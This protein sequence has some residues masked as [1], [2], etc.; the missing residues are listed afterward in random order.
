MSNNISE[1]LINKLKNYLTNN[2]LKF[3]NEFSE[4][5]EYDRTIDDSHEN[6]LYL[7]TVKI[8]D[9]YYYFTYDYNKRNILVKFEILNMNILNT[10]FYYNDYEN[11]IVLEIF[12]KYMSDDDE[13]F[14]ERLNNGFIK[15]M[16]ILNI[17]LEE[18][19]ERKNDNNY[20]FNPAHN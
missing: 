10:A 11:N 19:K 9:Y 18:N 14:T 16:K 8:K 17:Y 6:T 5:Q 3:I 4:T 12:V 1:K 20:Q 2:N 15:F 7:H 13:K